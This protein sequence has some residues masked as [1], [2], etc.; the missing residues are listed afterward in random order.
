MS[1]L[2]EDIASTEKYNNNQIFFNMANKCL[3]FIILLVLDGKLLCTSR[4]FLKN[5]KT[6]IIHICE[7]DKYTHDIHSKYNGPC[8]HKLRTHNN[9]L[10]KFIQNNPITRKNINTFYADTMG[11]ISGDRTKGIHIMQTLLQYL[12]NAPNEVVLG[13]TLCERNAGKIIDEFR[14]S[15]QKS[16]KQNYFFLEKIFIITNYKINIEEKR[17]YRRCDKGQYMN[18]FCFHITK[19]DNLH[20]TNKTNTHQWPISM[21]NSRDFYGLPCNINQILSKYNI[22]LTKQKYKPFIMNNI[23]NTHKSNYQLRSK[24]VITSPL[25][26]YFIKNKLF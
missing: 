21:N 22:L 4:I 18:F 7:D 6:K 5:E 23:K 24:G 13:V 15:N 25:Y 1:K 19:L 12:L 26:N 9:E 8:S 14:N 17:R 2:Y 16:Y 10:T 11:T 20:K 3:A